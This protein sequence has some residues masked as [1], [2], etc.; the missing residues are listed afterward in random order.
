[1]PS[2]F[3]WLLVLILLHQLGWYGMYPNIDD[4]T[5]E[6]AN[7]GVL[8]MFGYSFILAILTAIL[9]TE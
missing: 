7:Q 2:I 5:T 3:I 6:E 1:M 9:V 8:D 4:A